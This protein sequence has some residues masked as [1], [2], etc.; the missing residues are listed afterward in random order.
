MSM[1]SIKQEG[2]S[3]NLSVH[4][5]NDGQIIIE[6]DSDE[7]HQPYIIIDANNWQQVKQ[8]VDKLLE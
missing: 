7:F 6:H 2:D 5:N 1:V 8:A 3:D 4:L